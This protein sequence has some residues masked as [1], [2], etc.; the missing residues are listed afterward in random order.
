MTDCDPEQWSRIEVDHFTKTKLGLVPSE[1]TYLFLYHGK[2]MDD[3]L[4]MLAGN[5]SAN[6]MPAEGAKEGLVDL[7]VETKDDAEG[8][9]IRSIL[10]QQIDCLS[11]ILN[12][13]KGQG[14]SPHKARRK[15]AAVK[16][17]FD[18]SKLKT[19]RV[20]R[21][22][23]LFG[24]G[25]ESIFQLIDEDI[26][27]SPPEI[28]L[29]KEAP[30]CGL[31]TIIGEGCDLISDVE[32]VE[33][34]EI[35][36]IGGGVTNDPE[37]TADQQNELE[38]TS[39]NREKQG[40]V[41]AKQVSKCNSGKKNGEIVSKKV[42]EVKKK[43]KGKKHVLGAGKER[44]SDDETL[45]KLR[46][47]AKGKRKVGERNEGD[48]SEKEQSEE[49][50]PNGNEEFV[51]SDYGQDRAE[52]ERIMKEREK[53]WSDILKDIGKKGPQTQTCY[54][55]GATEESDHEAVSD[56][57]P[58]DDAYEGSDD[59]DDVTQQEVHFP[60][61]NPNT[62]FDNPKFVIGLRFATKAQFRE[63]C[64]HQGVIQGKRIRFSRNNKVKCRAYCQGNPQKACEWFVIINFRKAKGYLQI[65]KLNKNHGCG[66]FN[67]NHG[68]ATSDYLAARMK[69]DIRITP[70]LT[71]GQALEP[72]AVEWLRTHTN[73]KNWTRSHFSFNA[74]CGILVNNISECANKVLLPAR[75]KSL[76]PMLKWIMVYVMERHHQ[77]RVRIEKLDDRFG[78]KIRRNIEKLKQ[79]TG[80][81]QAPETDSSQQAPDPR[82][83]QLETVQPDCPPTKKAKR[84][85]VCGLCGTT[86]HYR[87]TCM[88]TVAGM[89][90]DVSMPS[91]EDAST[92]GK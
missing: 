26:E 84:I 91:T 89:Y 8:E 60:R 52:E 90:K 54:G 31:D 24:Q 66:G 35:Q 51:D 7:F 42:N 83:S 59:D 70:N 85:V 78:P 11:Q 65:T 56:P 14:P 77:K 74:R 71:I 92:S 13:R 9:W 28:E 10:T 64:K 17:K 67:H 41:A 1:L 32:S 15:V 44:S 61:Y 58:S 22:D 75:E 76:L 81:C 3:G 18:R 21:Q 5:D 20:A 29:I 82:S 87:T 38:P 37:P 79:M 73:A 30:R 88:S 43:A 4:A 12:E 47:R 86:G 19:K 16:K 53:E 69:D 33:E 45:K 46:D 34:A 63:V 27:A 40:E 39:Y 36:D 48:H 68:C 6:K 50:E 2:D 62:D 55:N 25:G 49:V 57:L 80:A 72:R 23:K